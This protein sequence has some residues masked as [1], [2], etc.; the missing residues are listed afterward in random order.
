VEEG[1]ER[2]G[3]EERELLKSAK[4]GVSGT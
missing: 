3:D 2:E 1:E 4:F